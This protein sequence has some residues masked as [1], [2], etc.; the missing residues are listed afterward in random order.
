MFSTSMLRIYR[1]LLMLGFVSASLFFV[2]FIDEP[3]AA[4]ASS[5]AQCIEVC[6]MNEDLC[7]D[8]CQTSCNTTDANCNSCIS[9]CQGE[10]ASCMSYAVSCPD[11]AITT[12]PACQVNFGDHCP[13]FG[14][15]PLCDPF[16]VHGGFF[17][18]CNTIGGNSCVSCPEGE[19]C[20]LPNGSLPPCS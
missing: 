10:F 19:Q 5:S 13:I 7:I 17:Q 16:N 8:S 9:N 12:S 4:I 11:I 2:G 6:I 14:G 1:R 15:E 18:I 3:V 20:V